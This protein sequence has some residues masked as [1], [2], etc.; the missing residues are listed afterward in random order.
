MYASLGP[1]EFKSKCLF[2][3]NELV[4]LYT[5]VVQYLVFKT[6]CGFQAISSISDICSKLIS[7]C[8]PRCLKPHG[9]T[10]PQWVNCAKKHIFSGH[11]P[12]TL[13]KFLQKLFNGWRPSDA[14]W[15]HGSSIWHQAITRTL[16]TYCLFKPLGKTSLKFRYVKC[17]AALAVHIIEILF[18]VWTCLFATMHHFVTEMSTFLLQS[19]ALWDI[20]L[21]HCGICEIGQLSLSGRRR[22]RNPN[23]YHAPIYKE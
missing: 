21:V 3:M 20:G 10:K 7:I 11:T 5:L 17:A 18:P 22:F 9:S 19:G 14:I 16:L 12:V 4:V 15:R 13:T 1:N 2:S 23:I 6:L 8:W